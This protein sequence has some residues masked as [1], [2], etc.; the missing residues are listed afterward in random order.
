MLINFLF[1]VWSWSTFCSR[2]DGADR[3]YVPG[4]ALVSSFPGV[5][6]IYFLFHVWRWSTFFPGVALIYLFA[7][8]YFLLWIGSS[9][10]CFRCGADQLFVP[11]VAL[12]YFLFL[13]CAHNAWIGRIPP[14]P[15]T[16]AG[17]GTEG[18]Q[19]PLLNQES[20]VDRWQSK[21]YR[22]IDKFF[23]SHIL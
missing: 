7:P 5:E 3:L 16:L 11:G 9:N 13:K 19:K 23:W 20:I 14:G 21:E 2:C 6:L 15:R 4:V 22:K 12:I 1:Q 8:V 17:L 10:F 18:V